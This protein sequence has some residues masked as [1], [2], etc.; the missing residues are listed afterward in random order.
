MALLGGVPAFAR[1]F[2]ESPALLGEVELGGTF[3]DAQLGAVR[4][5]S[6]PH[7]G[8]RSGGLCG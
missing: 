6:T 4:C 5:R 1:L 2:G 8:R 7:I 3:G